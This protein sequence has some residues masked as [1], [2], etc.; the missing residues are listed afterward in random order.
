MNLTGRTF[1]P[2]SYSLLGGRW[3]TRF[4]LGHRSLRKPPLI[5]NFREYQYHMRI[6]PDFSEDTVSIAIAMYLTA[7]SFPHLR[8]SIEPFSQ[9]RERWLGADV[10]LFDHVL[11][12]YPF[13]MQFKRPQAYVDGSNAKIIKDRKA[14]IPTL[15]SSPHA[16]FFS[17]REKLPEHSDYQHN[18]LWKLNRRLRRHNL[19]DAAYVCPLFLS[20]QAYLTQAH[21][22]SLCRLS[23]SGMWYPYEFRDV[24]IANGRTRMNFGRVPIFKEH[25]TIPP[26]AKV[27]SAKHSYSFLKDGSGVCFHS[28]TSLP[29]LSRRLSSWLSD[30]STVFLGRNNLVQ[31]NSA[32]EQLASL[33]SDGEPDDRLDFVLDAKSREEGF[34]LWLKWGDYLSTHYAIEQYAFIAYAS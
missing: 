18:I 17:L 2:C 27:S 19:G 20:R 31:R 14:Q 4:P 8:F 12:I 26:H 7:F 1:A 22:S 24:L 13:Y 21:K 6:D 10:R 11:G 5:S 29:D 34:S 15:S 3:E 32:T 16:L 30:L 25:V 9:S 28:P 23:G 33:L